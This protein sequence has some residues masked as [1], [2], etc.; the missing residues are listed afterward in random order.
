VSDLTGAEELMGQESEQF[1]NGTSAHETHT[2][3]HW[4]A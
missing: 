1:L 4:F 3:T 2:H